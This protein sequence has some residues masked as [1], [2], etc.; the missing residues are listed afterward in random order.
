MS[1]SF[2]TL[3]R[4]GAAAAGALACAVLAPA[5]QAA[6]TTLSTEQRVTPV[7]AWAGTIAW[8]TYDAATDSFRLVISR[9]GGPPQPLGVASSP[10][11]FDV[12]LGTNR[13]GSTY[14]VY[15]RC[16]TPAAPGDD[17][18]R[19]T[20]CDVYRTNVATANEQR[21]TS[22]SS[23]A[24]DEREPTI[25]RG[26]IA[27][28]RRETHGGTTK[29]VLRVA[30]TTSSSQGTRQLTKVTATASSFLRDPELSSDRV[31]YI[32]NLRSGGFPEQQMHTITLRALNDRIHYR[33]RSGGLN[34]A[35]IAGLAVSDTLKS[36]VW[37]RTNTGSG[38][39]NRLTRLTISSGQITY[40]QGSGRYV[41]S[42]WV[43]PSLGAVVM[44][45]GSGTGTC[46][47]GVTDPPSA[48]RCSVQVTGSVTWFASP[49]L[50]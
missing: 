39:G 25:M 41:S 46:F 29:D 11:A 31:G 18:R 17:D 21:L 8:S 26:E 22:I 14:A 7:A 43:N 48:T 3:K 9:D 5:A 10:V 6:N 12:D 37:A 24:W 49:S 36:F 35:N 38:T 42:S 15:T 19:G 40:A 28:I 32:R 23:P 1:P 13:S 50:G 45:D 16:A 34:A 33:A 47:E 2:T 30:N 44:V 20:D 27:F 4:C